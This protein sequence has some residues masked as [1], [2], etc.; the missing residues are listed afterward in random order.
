MP[1]KL[2]RYFSFNS[3]CLS[4]RMS[5]CHP[6]S[7]YLSIFVYNKERERGWPSFSKFAAEITLIEKYIGKE[8]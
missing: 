3:A 7:T 5:K 8:T 6:F 4:L 2:C 1:A